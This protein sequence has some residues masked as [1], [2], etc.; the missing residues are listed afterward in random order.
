MNNG[1]IQTRDRVF[2]SYSRKDKK[3]LDELHAQMAFHVRKGLISSWDDSQI[4]PGNR[5]MDDI[6]QA[7][8]STKVAVFLVSADFLASNFIAEHELAP[9]L[10]AAEH[11]GVVVLSVILGACAFSATPL[12]DFQAINVPSRPLNQMSLG[13]RAV[14]WSRAIDVIKAAL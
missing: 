3:Y 9:L 13:K 14:V 4:V 5:W 1:L 10:K 8:K 12:A 7:I 2:I 11:E 6:T